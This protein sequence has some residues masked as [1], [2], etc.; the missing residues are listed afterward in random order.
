MHTQNRLKASCAI[1]ALLIASSPAMAQTSP[2]ADDMETIVVTGMRKSL[3]NAT[4]LKRNADQ[5]VD[6]IVAE[7]VGKMPDTN[8]AELL[9]RIP[10]V[11]IARNT[12]GE[13]NAY[14]VHGLKQVTT[15]VNGRQLFTVA[16]RNATL[17][18]FSSDILTGIDVYKTATADQIE[19]GLGGLIDIHSARPFD[20]SG[21]FQGAANFTANIS[22]VQD[23][24]RP[25]LSGFITNRWDTSVGEIGLLVG[26]QKER[27]ESGGYSTSINNY[28]S[29]NSIF[30]RDADG[31]FPGD[32]DD[33]VLVPGQ[34]R[35]QYEYGTRNREAVYIAGQ[36]RPREG[37]TFHLD[38]IYS[39]S[40]GHSET[41][42]LSIRDGTSDRNVTLKDGT[43]I[44]DTYGL[45][46]VH[47][48]SVAGATDNPYHNYNV[49]GGFK[50]LTGPLTLSGEVAWAKSRGPFYMRS[51]TLQSTL[52]G[53]RFD[54][55]GPAVDF[56]VSGIDLNDP[57]SWRYHSV[58]DFATLS[59]GREK[60]LR[61]DG[62]YE[63]DWGPLKAVSA[64]L[65]YVDHD[66]VYDSYSV[67]YNTGNSGL[68]DT[69]AN[70]TALTPGRLF[71][72]QDVSTNQW[73]SIRRDIL[74]DMVAMREATG[75]PLGNPAFNQGSHYTYN[76]KVSAVY[77]QGHFD[78]MIGNIPVDGNIGV[79][80]VKTE[81]DQTVY[82]TLNGVIT[83]VRGGGEYDNTL[84]TF[85][86]RAKFTEDLFLRLAAS[87]A[88]TRPDYGNL[89]P[90]LILSPSSPTGSGGN[91]DLK[92][93]EANQ[94]DAALEYY[95]G[96]SNFVA[97]TVFKKDVEGFVQSFADEETI[98]GTP[99]LITRPRNSGS[100]EIKGASLAYQQFFDFL[101]APFDGLGVQGNYTYVDSEL[102]VI[103]RDVLVPAEG[104]SRDSYNLTGIYEKGPW[105]LHASYNWRSRSVQSTSGDSAGRTLWRAP[106]ESLDFAATYQ[107]NEQVSVKFDAVNILYSSEDRYFVNKLLPALSNQNDR[108]MHLGVHLK[109]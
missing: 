49:A 10:G 97:L 9:Q 86:L 75:I 95:F 70:L 27:F 73:V 103:G 93:A 77:L 28:S 41:Q 2:P 34:V 80:H 44:A 85:N 82:P 56:T 16:N 90:A 106:Y 107:V 48:R 74:R 68:T 94:Y 32:A 8:I 99:Y 72:D 102:S 58:S 20:Y 33:A 79:R 39:Y 4:T 51:I 45:T 38:S 92:P 12:R 36:W 105:S 76:E 71:V 15:T 46:N 61:L 5:V 17:L 26:V 54:M 59:D 55:S 24:I 89:S 60:S 53:V 6:S 83:E 87:K 14:V 1:L 47:A 37:L 31:N 43:N 62:R 96:G 63:L 64:G 109:F 67:G 81:G 29:S 84:P 21:G 88:I 3:Q 52:P 19:G 25:R 42:Q 18:D 13:G 100:G 69:V 66:T 23:S 50:W 101:P 40:G 78:T 57:A 65:R 35:G 108:S 22:D 104:L 30:D 11:Q 7:D 91:P 98:N